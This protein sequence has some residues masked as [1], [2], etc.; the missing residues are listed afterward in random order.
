MQAHFAFLPQQTQCAS[1]ATGTEF[2]AEYTQLSERV[3]GR[4]VAIGKGA[5]YPAQMEDVVHP[6]A[7][8]AGRYDSSV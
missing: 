3:Q 1:L 8:V 7:G 6:Y 4:I 5:H 2:H